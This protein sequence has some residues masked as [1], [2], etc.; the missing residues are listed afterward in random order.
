MGLV[1]ISPRLTQSMNLLQRGYIL[2]AVA[3]AASVLILESLNKTARPEAPFVPVPA[4]VGC[5]W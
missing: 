3:T 2:S 5:F 1:I 4:L